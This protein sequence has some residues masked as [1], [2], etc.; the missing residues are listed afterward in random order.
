MPA[1]IKIARW[2]AED[3][4]ANLPALVSL[5]KNVVDEGA[6]I[7][8]L[9]PLAE[10]DA[11]HYWLGVIEAV[12][13]GSRVLLAALVEGVVAG[14]AQLD[15]C[16]KPNGVHRAEVMK[17]MVRMDMRRRGVA[18]RLMQAIENEA[19]HFHR[20]TLVL[21]TRKG[22]PSEVLYSSLGWVRAGEI[23][24]Y[25]ISANGDIDPSVFYYKLLV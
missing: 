6:S 25:A 21:D 8:F 14:S 17:V 3:A 15:L 16:Q 1:M 2:H 11:Q 24:R 9:P 13:A 22:D 23:P 18:R 20:S 5:L 7:G 12:S 19:R 10:S 4:G